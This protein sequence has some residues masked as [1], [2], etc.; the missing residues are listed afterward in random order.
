M[1]K[2]LTK[3]IILVFPVVVLLSSCSKSE[4]PNAQLNADIKKID[5]YLSS[6]GLTNQVWYDN[7]HGIRFKVNTYG[8]GPPPH[9]GQTVK[10]TY[11][12][13]L[14]D[15]TPFLPTTTVTDLIDNIK[16][17][18]LQYTLGALLEGSAATFYIP[19]DY[20]YGK[21]GTTGVPPNSVL[22]Y[23]VFLE[24]VQRTT[25]QQTQFESDTA[26][27]HQFITQNE[28]ADA[29]QHSSGIWYRVTQPG[30]GDHPLP[31]NNVFFDYTVRFLT[32]PTGTIETGH[33]TGNNIFGSMIDGM[34]IGLPLMNVGS[35]VTFYIP[36]GLAYG[37]VVNAS[38]P[39]NSNLI[40]EVSLT[41]IQK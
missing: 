18:G 28:I 5:E 17:S 40:F 30:T 39:P 4:D 20:G 14:L 41:S 38:I 11:S 24:D 34:K 15:G 23:D 6:Q 3:T 22:I 37:P 7:S 29:V 26:A 32:N 21:T 27:I 8:E 33:I 12:G 16:P 10:V 9:A 25:T 2:W 35:K 36:S 31:Y 1:K 19:S 13:R